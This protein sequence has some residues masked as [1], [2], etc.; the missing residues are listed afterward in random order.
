MVDNLE[1]LLDVV[2]C[3]ILDFLRV[4]QSY[5]QKIILEISTICLWLF[6]SQVSI[7]CKNP[8]YWMEQVSKEKELEELT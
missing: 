2:I 1:P 5:A 4:H 3:S 6:F 8:H 7:L